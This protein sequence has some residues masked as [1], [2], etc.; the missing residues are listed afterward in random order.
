MC[1]RHRSLH[2]AQ[3]LYQL[4]EL[5]G[6]EPPDTGDALQQTVDA[7]RLLAEGPSRA[8]ICEAGFLPPVV[9]L[10]RDGAA[11]EAVQEQA[12]RVLVKLT[13]QEVTVNLVQSHP[14][15]LSALA[16][17]LIVINPSTKFALT[18]YP[19]STSVEDL[20]LPRLRS[21]S[22]FVRTLAQIVIRTLL[23]AGV[24]LIAVSVPSFARVVSFIGAFCS[25]VV[26]GAFPPACYVKLYSDQLSRGTTVLN[27][28]LV[29]VCSIC[30]LIGTLAA[31]L[32]P[33]N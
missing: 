4:D 15:T 30:S 20:L 10:L 7:L 28:T 23:T 2:R 3:S 19:V 11:S 8:F 29:V 33:T 22:T 6:G 24:T 32:C 5:L 21:T 18:L 12:T 17:W 14:G 9:G 16:T 1:G 27:K 25:F 31:I 13:A 26:S